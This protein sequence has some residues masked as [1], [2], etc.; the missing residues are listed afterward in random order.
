MLFLASGCASHDDMEFHP[1]TMGPKSSARP[2]TNIPPASLSKTNS[3]ATNLTLSPASEEIHLSVTNKNR[4]I[5]L[6]DPW[7]GKVAFV[8]PDARFV[9]LDYS[10]SQMPPAGQR[11]MVFRK[12]MRVGEVRISGQP[13]SGFVAADITA[14]DIQTGD[15]TRRE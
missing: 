11:L 9:I 7:A 12:G 5:T 4:V 6:T 2:A 10:L 1:K 3:P 13:Q 8:N 14:G 15:E